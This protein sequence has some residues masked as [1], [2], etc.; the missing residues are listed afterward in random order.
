MHQH[1]QN[2][3]VLCSVNSINELA[4]LLHSDQRRLQLMASR[5]SYKAFSIPKKPHRGTCQRPQKGVG[6]P[7]SLFAKHL[8]I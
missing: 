5:P 1:Q 2:K 3:A 8:F 7:Q 6:Y 4:R